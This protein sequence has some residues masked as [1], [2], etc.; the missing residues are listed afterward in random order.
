MP[1]FF[2]DDRRFPDNTKYYKNLL[3]NVNGGPILHKLKH[4]PPLFDEM[5]PSFF[6]AYDESTHFEQLQKDLALLHLKPHVRNTVYAILQKY[7]SVFN[8]KG[9]FIPVK[10]Y[11]CVIDTGE[12][13][14]IA[15]KKTI[16]GPKEPPI[17]RDAIAALAKVG[18][19]WQIHDGHWLFKALLAPR[20]HQEHV[21]DINSFVY[22]AE[23][24]HPDNCLPN[25][26]LQFSN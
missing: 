10:N 6:C 15:I 24:S 3:H 5:D 19:I 11:K 4:P 23:L 12:A 20:P 8:D 18:H 9:V 21:C 1:N 17:M 26:M 2:V 14:P 7:W 25:P 16:Y 22:S 13:Q